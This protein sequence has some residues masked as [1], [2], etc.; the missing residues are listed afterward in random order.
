MAQILNLAPR[1]KDAGTPATGQNMVV[2]SGSWLQMPEGWPT[3][4]GTA[5]FSHTVVMDRGAGRLRLLETVP[6]HLG[7]DQTARSAMTLDR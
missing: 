1:V 6:E 5:D 3:Q 2:R 4:V 7:V